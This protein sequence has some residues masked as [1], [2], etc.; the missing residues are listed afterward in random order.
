MKKILLLGATGMLGSMTYHVL[1]DTHK[2][3][4]VCRDKKKLKKLDS[5]YGGLS[6]HTSFF[7]DFFSLY[8]DFLTGFTASAVNPK[9]KKI[10]EKIG[11]V[12]AVINC[13]GIINRFA[14]RNP[15]ET[16]F[17]NA[18]VPHLLSTIYNDKLI[19]VTTDCVFSGLHGAPYSEK[20]HHSPTDLYGLTKSLGEPESHSFVL[21]TSFIGP[22]IDNF[23]S[24]LSWFQKQNGQT[25]HGYTNHYWNGITTLEFAR[26]CK[27]IVASRNAFP[28]TGLFH[29][30]STP[31]SK[32]EMLSRL[33]EK[34]KIKVSIKP[35]QAIPPIDR[36]LTSCYNV[37]S[38]LHISSFTDMVRQLP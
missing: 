27:Q 37:C 24:L 16:Y 35:H 10:I 36:R 8:E 15:L 19:H 5:Q 1:K 26:V 6:E 33:K 17:I 22:E 3:V 25:V 4:L 30:F 23:V 2:L 18:V 31:V 11:P 32:Y 34:Y 7:F 14:A 13:A 28:K 9:L 12:D 38:Q 20:S 29:I 21:R